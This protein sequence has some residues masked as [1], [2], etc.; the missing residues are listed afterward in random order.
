MAERKGR[1]STDPLLQDLVRI[2]GEI[3][4]GNVED[5]TD[6]SEE[7]A[8]VAGDREPVGD[9]NGEVEMNGDV[10]EAAVSEDAGSEEAAES[11]GD[12]KAAAEDVGSEEAAESGGDE[13]PAAETAGSGEPV[14]SV[15]KRKPATAG[16]AAARPAVKKK[17][18]V[19]VQEGVERIVSRIGGAE[20]RLMEQAGAN[21]EQLL[22]EL[23]EAIH[24]AARWE[25]RDTVMEVLSGPAEAIAG[26]GHACAVLASVARGEGDIGRGLGEA[27]G[28]LGI[29]QRYLDRDSVT[30]RGEAMKLDKVLGT[31]GRVAARIGAAKQLIGAAQEELRF[32]PAEEEL[33]R[34][35]AHAAMARL[36]AA[37]IEMATVFGA[38]GNVDEESLPHVPGVDRGGVPESAELKEARAFRLDFYRAQK[39][40][41]RTVRLMRYGSVAAAVVGAV[42]LGRVSPYFDGLLGSVARALF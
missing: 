16:T 14:K 27:S 36:G 10:E 33:A 26:T 41:D 34:K 7:K 5:L 38:V 15:E 37:Q 13:K 19:E 39:R 8:G 12:E 35:A 40:Q 30:V 17:D 9:G 4:A 25:V 32:V 23:S 1:E 3:N 2:D 11:G 21:R 42:A 6:R 31:E 18:P 29:V 22:V 28:V 24:R 20:R